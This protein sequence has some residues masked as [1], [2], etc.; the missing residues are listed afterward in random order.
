M[1][2]GKL[3]MLGL[4]VALV[5]SLVGIAGA[6]VVNTPAVAQVAGDSSGNCLPKA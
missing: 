5:L 3:G 1:R 4:V 2:G 6:Q